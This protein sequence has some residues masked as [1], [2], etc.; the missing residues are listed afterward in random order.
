VP[1]Q[2]LGP[3]GFTPFDPGDCL[4]QFALFRSS[5]LEGLFLAV[6]DERWLRCAREPK[7]PASK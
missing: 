1:E 4:E 3:N 2:I 7:R 5:G 6:R